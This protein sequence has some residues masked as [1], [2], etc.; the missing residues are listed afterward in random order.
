MPKYIDISVYRYFSAS[1][2]NFQH[3]NLPI[4][5][6]PWTSRIPSNRKRTD[7]S[8]SKPKLSGRYKPM[9]GRPPVM[10]LLPASSATTK[11]AV[12]AMT[13]SM[14]SANAGSVYRQPA[15][16]RIT[17]FSCCATSIV[18]NCRIPVPQLPLQQ[19]FAQRV[20][21]IRALQAAQAASRERTEHLFQSML[22]RAFSQEL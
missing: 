2:V 21:E 11:S 6:L 10:P 18:K 12:G 13:A 20:S 8:A 1:V 15:E 14:K 19:E 9:M 4:R 3:M 16:Y 7:H 5:G 22:H 17:A